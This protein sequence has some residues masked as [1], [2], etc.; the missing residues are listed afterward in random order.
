MYT[1]A[2][3]TAYRLTDLIQH[4]EDAFST[5]CPVMCLFKQDSPAQQGDQ[6]MEGIEIQ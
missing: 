4:V 5:D 3:Y 2:C 6:E 1:R